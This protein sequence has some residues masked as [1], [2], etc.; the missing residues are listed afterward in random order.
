MLTVVVG[1]CCAGKSTYVAA[2]RRADDV[3]VDVD[4]L[5][6]ALGARDPRRATAYQ[7]AAALKARDAV[8]EQAR[9]GAD[10]DVWLIHSHPSPERLA[11]Y[12]RQGWAVV[13][14]DPGMEE[15]MRRAA[16]DARPRW[17]REAIAAWYD[18][19]PQTQGTATQSAAASRE[20]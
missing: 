6:A 16:A 14:V 1:P 12:R 9:Q 8:V 20:W 19:P 5:C 3:V 10:A 7:R 4:D 18:A 17:T 15:C 11:A 2:K 13:V